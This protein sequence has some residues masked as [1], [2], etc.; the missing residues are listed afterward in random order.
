M[1]A[2]LNPQLLLGIALA[3]AAAFGAGYFDGRSDGR[4]LEH[5]ECAAA[6]EEASRIAGATEGELRTQVAE[7]SR[8]ASL[9]RQLKA[10]EIQNFYERVVADV[11]KT[12][13]GVCDW[14]DP[15]VRRLNAA[16]EGRFMSNLDGG[17]AAVPGPSIPPRGRDGP[18]EGESPRPGR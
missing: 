8:E 5:A 4:K 15:L 13:V 7:I 12:A 18:S 14:P 16:A 10:P 6:S 3:I 17:K 2:L 11:P 1:L 9:L